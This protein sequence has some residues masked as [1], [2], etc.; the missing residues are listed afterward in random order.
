MLLHTRISMHL[1]M[2]I[3]PQPL[4]TIHRVSLIRQALINIQL[5]YVTLIM[6][7]CVMEKSWMSI[8]CH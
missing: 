4:Y 7:P 5:V 8:Q 3:K 2:E 6:S 1:E